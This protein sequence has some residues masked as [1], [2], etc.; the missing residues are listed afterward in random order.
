MRSAVLAAFAVLALALPVAAAP[1][2]IS[3]PVLGLRAATARGGVLV[4]WVEPGSLANSL[5]IGGGDV[6]ISCNG[7]RVRTAHQLLVL[8]RG[9]AKSDTVRVEVRRHGRTFGFS[10][11]RA[12]D[13]SIP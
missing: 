4:L 8:D 11:Y 2:G 7:K 12:P 9:F 13:V 6:I 3:D 5:G 1:R 10:I